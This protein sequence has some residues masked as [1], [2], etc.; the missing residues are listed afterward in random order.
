MMWGD[1]CFENFSNFSSRLT[2]EEMD[3]LLKPEI[4]RLGARLIVHGFSVAS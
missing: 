1:Q 4:D 2:A 3:G